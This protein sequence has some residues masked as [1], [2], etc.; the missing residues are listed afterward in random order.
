M[1]NSIDQ[2]QLA[3]NSNSGDVSITL[4]LSDL[5]I[6]CDALQIGSNTAML[7]GQNESSKRLKNILDQIMEYSPVPKRS[8]DEGFGWY[9]AISSMKSAKTYEVYFNDSRYRNGKSNVFIEI[10]GI[11]Y[12]ITDDVTESEAREISQR[13]TDTLAQHSP[14]DSILLSRIQVVFD[15]PKEAPYDRSVLMEDVVN[16]LTPILDGVT[17]WTFRNCNL[18]YRDYLIEAEL[19]APAHMH[20][21]IKDLVQDSPQPDEQSAPRL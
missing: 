5:L 7:Y 8:R 19:S 9:N 6:V 21:T 2:P 20:S 10:N 12:P 13:V 14:L 11:P 15:L 4:H 17:P 3:S 16:H 1:K 18:R